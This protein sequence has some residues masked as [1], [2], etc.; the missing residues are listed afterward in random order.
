L[1]KSVN[2]YEKKELR[3]KIRLIYSKDYIDPNFKRLYYTRY[4]DDFIVGMAGTSREAIQLK[5]KLALF[6]KK[7]LKLNLRYDK[8]KL[9]NLTKKSIR[10]LGVDIKRRIPREKPIFNQKRVTPRLRMHA[11]IEELFQKGL[12]NGFFKKKAGTSKLQATRLNRIVNL[13]HADIIMYYNRVIRGILN[14]YSFV[15]NKKRLGS[16]IHGFKHSCA[17]T[18]ARKFKLKHRAKV[19]KRFGTLLKDPVRGKQLTLPRTFKRTREF[20]VEIKL[21]STD[22]LFKK[23]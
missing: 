18:L 2:S 23:Q 20:L 21:I 13:D 8:T 17:L 12:E 5:E 3:K 11:P 7:K 14:Y 6:L 19:F 1:Y 22:E 4:A 9:T 16:L 15:D 10:F